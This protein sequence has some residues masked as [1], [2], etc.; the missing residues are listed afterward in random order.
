MKHEQCVLIAEDNEA[1]VLAL[2]R[3]FKQL[4][5][6][7]LLKVVENGAEVIAY[8]RGDGTFEDRARYRFPDLLLLDLKMPG[9]NGFEVLQWLRQQD[10]EIGRLRVVVL[11]SSDEIR[12]VNRAYMLGANSFLTKPLDYAEFKHCIDA[13]MRYWLSLSRA[14]EPPR[15]TG[16]IRLPS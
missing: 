15:Q 16:Q 12:D 5:V 9:T 3:A 1:D 14:P 7:A 4:G 11:T 6:P 10:G 2:R 8:L 13:T